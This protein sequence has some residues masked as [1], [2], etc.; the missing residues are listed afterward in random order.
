MTEMVNRLAGKVAIIAGAGAIGEGLSNGAATAILFAREGAKVVAVDYDLA[1]AE[2]TAHEI[3]KEAG[4]CVALRADVTSGSDVQAM[5]ATAAGHY[6][7]ADVLF[8]NVGV[9]SIGGPLET[10]EETWERVMRTNITSMYLTVKAVLPGMI[11][12]GRGSIVNNS[13]V[14]SSRSTYAC[15]P[16]ATSKAAVNQFTQQVG[17]QY[18]RQGIRCNAILPGYI[19]TPRVLKRLV[20]AHGESVDAQLAERANRVPAGYC[21]DAWDVAYAALYL[22]SDEAKYVTAT[23]LVVDGGLTAI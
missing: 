3:W 22:A 11:E 16:Y 23:T 14:V 8:N 12:K 17:V 6:G 15:L 10:D 9:Q 5:V 18:A 1:R 4:E 19:A 20:E 7:A 13:S 21:G 2:A